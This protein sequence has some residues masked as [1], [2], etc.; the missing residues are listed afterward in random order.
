MKTIDVIGY[1]SLIACFVVFVSALRLHGHAWK[2]AGKRKWLWVLLPVVTMPVFLSIPVLVWYY[3][4]T[5]PPVA[6]ADADCIA[7]RTAARNGRRQQAASRLAA[8]APAP[9]SEPI[10]L[11]QAPKKQPCTQCRSG[12]RACWHCQGRR[13]GYD[14]NG[15]QQFC[16]GCGG[17]GEET[18]TTCSGSGYV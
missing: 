7:V 1:S 3:A 18:C 11:F 6:R 12:R 5:R 8:S 9:G 13:G 10:N 4:R 2:E 16:S 15:N 17:S 14:A